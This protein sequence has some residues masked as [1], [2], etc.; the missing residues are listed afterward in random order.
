MADTFLDGGGVIADKPLPCGAWLRFNLGRPSA[1]VTV[2]VDGDGLRI[3]GQYRP[4]RVELVAANEL[5]IEVA[6]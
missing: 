2:H 5:R 6:G 3:V 4:L 1:A